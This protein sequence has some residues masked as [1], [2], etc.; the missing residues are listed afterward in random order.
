MAEKYG[1]VP[2]RF[3]KAWWEH[4]AYYYKW[5][6]IITAAAILIALVTIVQCAAREK[7]DMYV[8]YSGHMNY[9]D[10]E[11]KKIQ[12]LLSERIDD[13]D[14]NGEKSVLFQQLVFSDTAGSQEYDYA[15]QTKLDMTFGNDCS[16]IYLFDKSEASIQIQKSAAADIFETADVY[17]PDTGSETLAAPDGKA[18]AVSL[19]DSALLAK[20]GIY[21]DDL[22]IM[23]RKNYKNDEKNIKA[24][25]NSI[26]AAKALIQK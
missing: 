10:N 24:H 22:Y 19:A 5:H 3:T 21:K 1:V 18:Y 25:E 26:S 16:F 23:L 8:V 11:I 14:G 7:Y 9:S 13:I 15:I 4:M 2:P 6:A 17:T 12:E 20:N